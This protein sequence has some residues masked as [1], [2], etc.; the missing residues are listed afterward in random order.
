MT[1]PQRS[2]ALPN[3]KQVLFYRPTNLPPEIHP[4]PED[5]TDF[6]QDFPEHRG[7]CNAHRI[8]ELAKQ[9]K[10]LF[11]LIKYMELYRDSSQAEQDAFADELARIVSSRNDMA[12][13]VFHK[14]KVY[15]AYLEVNKKLLPRKYIEQN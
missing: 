6:V 15:E 11:H 5:A 4:G 1:E 9:G 2:Q 10:S 14:A 3:G 12:Y 7:I 13:T 8:F